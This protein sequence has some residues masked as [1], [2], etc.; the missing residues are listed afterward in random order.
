MNSSAHFQDVAFVCF[1]CASLTALVFKPRAAVT[2]ASKPQALNGKSHRL[3]DLNLGI[4]FCV[5]FVAPELTHACT[6]RV[7]GG[8]RLAG[9]QGLAFL[10]GFRMPGL[11][12]WG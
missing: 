9:I 8:F 1:C 6:F 5:L 3:L 7:V 2:L 10:E 12:V 4:H 11:G